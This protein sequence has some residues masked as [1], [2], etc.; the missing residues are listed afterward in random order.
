VIQLAVDGQMAGARGNRDSLN[1]VTFPASLRFAFGEN[2]RKCDVW[3]RFSKRMADWPMA[4]FILAA[5]STP[6]AGRAWDRRR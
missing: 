1:R 4:D 2:G 6:T 3:P 5:V